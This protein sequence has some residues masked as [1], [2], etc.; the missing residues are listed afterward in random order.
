MAKIT[1][2]REIAAPAAVVFESIA[3]PRKFA[4]AI[5]GVSKV[6]FLSEAKAG[7][8]VRYRQSRVMKG[9]ESTMDFEVTEHVKNERLRILNETHGTVWDSLFTLTP[10]GT[11][12]ALTMRMDTRSRPLLAKLLMPV[13]C[14][15][16]RGAVAKDIEAVKTYCESA[17][18]PKR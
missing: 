8:G 3:D 15:M 1:V 2:V 6:E 14:L 7:V 12:T 10:S 5:S 18:T 13:I 11:G 17:A 9:R 16:I 4:Q